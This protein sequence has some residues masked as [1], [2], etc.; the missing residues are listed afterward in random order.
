MEHLPL[1]LNLKDARCLVVGGGAVAVRKIRLL[2]RA[3]AAVTVVAPAISRE[4]RALTAPADPSTDD[5]G[6]HIT[7]VPERFSPRH[8]DGQQL[9]V[10]ATGDGAVDRLVA[11]EAKDRGVWCNVVD[12]LDLSTFIFPAIV[13]RSPVVV[14]IG[15]S[16]AAPVLARRLK[17]QIESLLPARIG[18]LAARARRWRDLVKRRIP[19]MVA[20]RRFWERLF[21][22][23]I[24]RHVLA[25]RPRRAERDFTRALLHPVA[26]PACGEAYL[27]GAGPGDPGLITLRGRQLL[28]RADVVLYDALVSTEVLDYARKDATLI[29][30]GKKPGDSDRQDGITELLVRFVAEGNRV[31]RL[32]G[33]DPL[34]FG[35]G[36]EEAAALAAAGLPFEIV[37]GISAALGCAAS[38]GIPLTQRGVSSSVTFATPVVGRS[39]EPD[40]PLLAR[41]GH[42]LALYMSVGAMA[43]VTNDLIRHGMD[44][45]T[46]AAVVENGTSPR[47]RVIEAD[48]A[49]IARTSRAYRVRSPAIL[50]V[51]ASV[52]LRGQ[53]APQSGAVAET[54]EGSARDNGQCGEIRSGDDYRGDPPATATTTSDNSAAEAAFLNGA[55]RRAACNPIDPGLGEPSDIRQHP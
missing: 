17:G 30:V 38:A 24:A 37:P 49:T 1:F 16:G 13:D 2:R 4:L 55:A 3:G 32:K 21:D 47:Q 19:A 42:T 44:E 28:S 11:K 10:S 26:E 46:P 27:V 22:G 39:E 6:P 35:R 23:P 45:T 41:S 8:C 31:C 40:W 20:R 36:G 43:T 9:V 14:A 25:G 18:E 34:V 15:T 48:L 12:D 54:V 50:Y 33:G 29:A 53:L 51:G 7:L 52:A 5:P